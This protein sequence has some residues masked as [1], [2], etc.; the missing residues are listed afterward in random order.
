MKYCK[1]ND[2][3]GIYKSNY[4]N[5]YGYVYKHSTNNYWIYNCINI[6]KNNLRIR[7]LWCLTKEKPYE[8]GYLKSIICY[9]IDKKSFK[10]LN[11]DINYC[12]AINS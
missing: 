9:S 12:M 1:N 6:N 4:R 8:F 7:I 10:E 11:N 2:I 3:N 5:K